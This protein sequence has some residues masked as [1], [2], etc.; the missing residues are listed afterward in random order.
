L[1]LP[2]RF[3][4]ALVERTGSSA[5]LG[6]TLD[7]WWLRGAAELPLALLVEA[8]AQAAALAA[9][10]EEG[11]PAASSAAPEL[12]LGALAG[13]ELLRPLRAGERLEFEVALAG[14][15]GAMTR[16]AVAVRSAGETVA[17]LGLTLSA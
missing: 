7:A 11:V 2:H 15:F 5:R 12:R 10:G 14:R 8:A 6:L 13:C 4:F 1:T 17:R 16:V 3:P 9:E